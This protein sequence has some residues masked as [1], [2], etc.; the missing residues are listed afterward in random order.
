MKETGFNLYSDV[1][2]PAKDP[3]NGLLSSFAV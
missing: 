3:N 1:I 2:L